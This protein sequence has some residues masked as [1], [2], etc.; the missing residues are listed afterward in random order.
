MTLVEVGAWLDWQQLHVYFFTFLLN[1]V[2]QTEEEDDEAVEKSNQLSDVSSGCKDGRIL[3]LVVLMNVTVVLLLLHLLFVNHCHD[4]TA[5]V[6][7]RKNMG[8]DFIQ[9]FQGRVGAQLKT[10]F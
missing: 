9:R 7:I 1:N 4:H 6:Y 5:V 10:A 2:V 8:A 3:V